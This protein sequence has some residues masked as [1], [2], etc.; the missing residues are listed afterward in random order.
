M[1]RSP[2]P[3]DGVLEDPESRPS[4]ETSETD[5]DLGLTTLLGDG[6]ALAVGRRRAVESATCGPGDAPAVTERVPAREPV[7]VSPKTQLTVVDSTLTQIATSS[8]TLKGT[9][10]DS[11][12][13]LIYSGPAAQARLSDWPP[14]ASGF[15][16]VKPAVHDYCDGDDHDVMYWDENIDPYDTRNVV[17]REFSA[18]YLY[19]RLLCQMCF[20]SLGHFAP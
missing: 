6:E 5:E 4:S 19:R 3:P 7:I 17:R 15:D 8:T 20:I 18:V 14:C 1:G 13:T 10:T 12:P 16:N 9:A 2:G 11:I